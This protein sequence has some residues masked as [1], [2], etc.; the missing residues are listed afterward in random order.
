ML[1]YDLLPQPQGRQSE[2]PGPGIYQSY[3]VLDQD[4]PDICLP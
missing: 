1:L 2:A 4:L 3:L